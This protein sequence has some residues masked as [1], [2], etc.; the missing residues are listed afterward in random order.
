V[1]ASQAE[2]PNG[3]A[4]AVV[5]ARDDQFP[6]A[7]TGVPLAVTKDAPLLLSD[8]D[9]LDAETAAEI[10]RVLPAGG[11]VYLL[12]GPAALGTAVQ[13]AVSALGYQVQRVAGPTRYGTAVAIAQLL[14]VTQNFLEVDGTGF[15]D[16]AS[17][18]PAAVAWGGA[19]LLT[20]GSSQDP[21]TA[22]FL[23]SVNPTRKFAIGGPAAAAD[24]SATPL[25]GADRY[26]TAALV[27]RKFFLLA[28]GIGVATG[29]NFPDALTG[30]VTMAALGEP[31]LLAAPTF[32]SPQ[33]LPPTLSAYLSTLSSTLDTITV[34]GGTDAVSQ[35][36]AQAFQQA[37]D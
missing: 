29:L 2:F 15:A 9:S 36:V 27:A 32:T 34:F 14:G 16:A 31:L 35:A 25:V 7:L 4:G 13:A 5:L 10:Q 3:G 33:V 19:V 26:A 17:A 37:A 24:P 11:T 23:A 22:A 20:D 30:G 12:G 1:L 6:D 21:A 28:R 8:P 18:G